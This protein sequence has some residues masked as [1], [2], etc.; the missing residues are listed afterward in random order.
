[1]LLTTEKSHAKSGV[2]RVMQVRVPTVDAC[3][4]MVFSWYSDFPP[5]LKSTPMR[6][7]VVHFIHEPLGD[8][9]LYLR[10]KVYQKS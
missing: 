3:V 6:H 2:S 4:P 1:M 5:S 10:L 9:I 8:H 7:T